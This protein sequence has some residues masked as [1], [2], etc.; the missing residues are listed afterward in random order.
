MCWQR[1]YLVNISDKVYSTQDSTDR[2]S[3]DSPVCWL[4]VPSPSGA[5][6]GDMVDRDHSKLVVLNLT[7]PASTPDYLVLS[8]IIELVW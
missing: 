2:M 6:V 8:N 7:D 4:P 1:C 3:G 5:K